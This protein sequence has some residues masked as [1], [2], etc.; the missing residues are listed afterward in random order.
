MTMG[1]NGPMEREIE[2]ATIINVSARE[3]LFSL[4][5]GAFLTL[6]GI[7]GKSRL[8]LLLAALG[9][10][11]F[12][13]GVTGHDPLYD[14][15]GVNTA[16]KTN[17]AV[18]SV[19]HQQGVHVRK[20]ITINRSPAEL[21]N[22]WRNF[23]NLPRFM[24]NI[25]SVTVLS[26]TR[27]RWVVEGPAG[28]P[29]EWDA[30]IYN[31]IPNELIAWRTLANAQ[32]PHAGSVRFKLAPDGH[33]TEVIVTMDYVPPAGPLGAVMVKLFGKE[34]GQQIEEDLLNFKQL[35]ESQE[36]PA[37]PPSMEM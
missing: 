27:S 30:E 2:R 9:G 11:L 22:F 1:N 4:I 18:V 35:M 12:Q 19:P 23:E 7:I 31:E 29:V 26:P 28:I 5:G 34:P 15:L 21:Y 6:I 33:S 32:I 25:K 14:K 17:P 3:R 36:V 20:S 10:Y 24:K 8:G 13:R 16:V 37:S